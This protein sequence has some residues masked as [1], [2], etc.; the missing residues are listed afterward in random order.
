MA[1]KPADIG[2][3]RLISLA[4]DAWVQWLLD[5]S[6]VRTTDVL[7]ADF[8]WVGRETDAL[9]KVRSSTSGEFLVLNEVQLHYRPDMPLRMRAYAGLAAE[10]YKLP[11]VPVL[12]NILEPAKSLDIPGQYFSEFLGLVARQDYRVVNLWAIDAWSVLDKPV[13]PLVPFTPAMHGGADETVLQQAVTLLRSDET[14]SDLEPL[15]AFFASFVMDTDVIRSIMRWDMAV[16][17]ESPWYYEIHREGYEEGVEQGIEKG[18]EQGIEQGSHDA[19]LRSLTNLLHY[20][21]GPLPASLTSLLTSLP[22]A[23]LQTLF[24]VA[25]TVETLAEFQDNLPSN[26]AVASNGQSA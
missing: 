18:I 8:Q 19:A 5:D 2:S 17:R 24:D 25:L 3:K 7:S 6:E 13:L 22:A 9:L 14:L 21:F 11:V 26:V 23:H 12:I 15:L 1:Q 16:L 4:P 20:R 10:R